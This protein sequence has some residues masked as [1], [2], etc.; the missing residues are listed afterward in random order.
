MLLAQ[1][2]SL[3]NPDQEQAIIVYFRI[4]AWQGPSLYLVPV[5]HAD[6]CLVTHGEGQR[7]G[8]LS[9]YSGKTMWPPSVLGK[10]GSE[11]Q[12]PTGSP[13]LLCSCLP[14]LG[15]S[16]S[17]W[18]IYSVDDKILAISQ[19]SEPEAPCPAKTAACR[20]GRCATVDFRTSSRAHFHWGHPRSHA[21]CLS[22]YP[23]GGFIY[24]PTPSGA[25]EVP[26]PAAP[27]C[28]QLGWMGFCGC[29]T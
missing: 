17:H 11:L 23:P 28:T 14:T 26:I 27:G 24:Q 6:S 10:Q 5:S 8:M 15:H 3:R 12:I 13:R 1:G 16:W 25:E 19:F 7:R 21:D 20:K 9:G 18:L 22:D 2:L 29:P 4:S